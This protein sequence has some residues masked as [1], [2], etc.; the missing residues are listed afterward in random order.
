MIIVKAL[1]II[2]RTSILKSFFLCKKNLIMLLNGQVE[3]ARWRKKARLIIYN[4]HK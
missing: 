3:M 4:R 1:G 2:C